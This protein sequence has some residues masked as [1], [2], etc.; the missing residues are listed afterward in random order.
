MTWAI[1]PYRNNLDQT[2]QTVRDLLAQTLPSQILLIDQGAGDPLADLQDPRVFRCRHAP[3]LPSLSAVWNW[4]LALVWESG[5]TE[6][7]VVNNDVRLHPRTYEFLLEV[8][9]VTRAFFV[10]A[11]GVTEA[12]FDG[13]IQDPYFEASLRHDPLQK[14][15]PDFSC[16]LLTKACHDQYPFDEAFR[17][18]YCEDLDYH[19]RLLLAGDGD[20][21]FSVNLPYLHYASG[22]LKAMDAEARALLESDICSGSRAYYRQK[23]GGD[24]NQELYS[25]PF[26]PTSR[27]A[28]VTTSELQRKVQARA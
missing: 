23:W 5:G 20:K 24:V 14:G 15:G 10:S 17:P 19:R 28:G 18:A 25:R 4:A 26:D 21:I 7:L 16:F 3:P 11:V 27:G 22:T 6:A 1:V 12:Q 13:I 9:S 8:Q 2:R